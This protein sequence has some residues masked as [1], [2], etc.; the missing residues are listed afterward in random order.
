MKTL[1]RCHTLF[2]I[3]GTGILNR[4]VPINLLPEKITEWEINRNR[5]TNLDTVIQVLSLRTQPEELTTPTKSIVSFKNDERFGF[6]FEEEEDQSCWSFTFAIYYKHAYSDGVN[7]LGGLYS[8]CE[9]VPM[10]KVGTEWDKLPNFL[11]TSP[12]LRNI[13]FEVIHE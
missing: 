3:T 6:L 9:G 4:K 5:Q 8:D 7:E 1:I 2:D 11:D 10:I 12:E 13:Y